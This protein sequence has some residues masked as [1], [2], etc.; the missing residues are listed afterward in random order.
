M[1]SQ[2]KDPYKNNLSFFFSKARG[3][4]ARFRKKETSYFCEGPKL[5]RAKRDPSFLR[6]PKRSPPGAKKTPGRNTQC[7]NRYE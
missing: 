5:G 6:D 1:P 7:P 4:A 2:H 3:F